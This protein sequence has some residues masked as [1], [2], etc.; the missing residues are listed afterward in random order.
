[1]V[2][3]YAEDLG[4]KS[5]DTETFVAVKAHVDNWRWAGVPFYLRTGKRMPQRFSE[6]VVQFRPVPHQIFP[7]Q[8]DALYT[9]KL[10]IRLQPDESIKLEMITKVPGPGGYRLK[11]VH[12]NLSL[13]EAFKDRTPDAYERLLMDVVRGNPTLFM[14][15]DEVEAAWVWAETILQG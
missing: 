13:S 10:I 6:I 7:D 3:G 9:N 8:G 5:S 11:P 1:P 15:S 2:M 4:Q 14:R 12:L